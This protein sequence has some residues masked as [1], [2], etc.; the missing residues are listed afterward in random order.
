MGKH[1]RNKSKPLCEKIAMKNLELHKLEHKL[2]EHN[3]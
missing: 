2:L 3:K 1:K